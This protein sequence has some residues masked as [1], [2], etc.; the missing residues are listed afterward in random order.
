[1]S[2]W[3]KIQIMDSHRPPPTAALTDSFDLSI[4]YTR[5]RS[6]SGVSVG[7]GVG[8]DTAPISERVCP[9]HKHVCTRLLERKKKA[10]S[11]SNE[12]HS[13]FHR[14]GKFSRLAW[15]RVTLCQ[16]GH[17]RERNTCRRETNSFSYINCALIPS[18]FSLLFS[19]H[20]QQKLHSL[21][22]WLV[23]FSFFFLLFLMWTAVE[24]ARKSC[25]MASA[26]AHC[27]KGRKAERERKGGLLR[28]GRVAHCRWEGPRTS[29]LRFC[30]CCCCCCC[31]CSV[32][33]GE[34][35]NVYFT[36]SKERKKGRKPQVLLL[37]LT[38]T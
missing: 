7:I 19:L 28:S 13:S 6:G 17:G 2:N 5:T 8:W 16:R 30:C 15:H 4:T 23:S 21:A 32:P 36:R 9:A 20:L 38:V 3:R 11:S 10:F 1:M 12:K 25:L 14:M 26:S 31:C 33:Q 22:H 37:L 27:C 29:L 18:L 24:D 34:A 35:Q